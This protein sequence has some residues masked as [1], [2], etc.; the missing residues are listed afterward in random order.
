MSRVVVIGG[1]VIGVTTGAAIARRGLKVTVLER[2]EMLGAGA[3]ARNGGQLSYSYTDALASPAILRDLPGLLAGFDP[4]FRIRVRL[5]P[6]FLAWGLKFLANCTATR[7]TENTRAVLRLALSS[8]V[9]LD[10]L[11]HRYPDLSFHHG[12]SGKLHLYDDRAKLQRAAASM[13]LKNRL[14]CEQR[15]LSR[16]E[17]LAVEPALSVSGRAFVGAIY[18][19]LDE[20]GDPRAFTQ[21]LA[22]IAAREYAMDI[23]PRTVAERFILDRGRIRAVDTSRGPI[24]GD[25]FV[26]ATGTDVPALARTA[27][28][29]V[30]IAA[31]KGYSITLPATQ[32]APVVSI[33]DT[34]A[35]I[36]FCRLGDRLRIAGMAELGRLDASIDARRIDVLLNAARACLPA[37]A[38]WQ[39]DP[40]PW[41]GLRPMTPDSRPIIGATRL[42]NLFLNCGH[43]ML[44]WT[45]ACGS[46]ELTARCVAGE[47]A[48]EGF[49][50]IADDFRLE[51]F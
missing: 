31:M 39:E 51:R 28:L 22:T 37:A 44:G 49:L 15:V 24:E 35:K 18:S 47:D 19:P 34:R 32:E 40:H 3:T 11:R 46:A 36:V 8:R 41:A 16:D 12:T 7:F 42:S 4:A 43:G 9:A 23:M 45:L 33:T 25:V 27:G 1:G 13:D 5:S 2:S 14:G 10:R 26:L 50:A 48:E 6:P 29:R 20:A 17:T 38:R 30:P 21:A